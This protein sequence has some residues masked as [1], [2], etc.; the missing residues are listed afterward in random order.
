MITDERLQQL[1]YDPMMCNVTPDFLMCFRELIEA[2]KQLDALK[3]QVEK[4]DILAEAGLCQF[5]VGGKHEF[6]KDI[7]QI[8]ADAEIQGGITHVAARAVEKDR[9]MSDFYRELDAK[10]E[11]IAKAR[12]E[13]FHAEH[14]NLHDYQGCEND[15]AHLQKRIADLERQLAEAQ[16]TIAALKG[17]IRVL[18]YTLNPNTLEQMI[19]HGAV[20]VGD[21]VLPWVSK[22][23]PLGLDRLLYNVEAGNE[24]LA[25]G[26][27][28]DI[29]IAL[30][31]KQ[32]A[33]SPPAGLRAKEKRSKL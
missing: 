13:Q 7:R 22:N 3:E 23:S 14:P 24:K 18:R 29:L 4:M 12:V 33:I 15:P 11:G 16:A 17:E 10:E 28:E 31:N 19:Q 25:P 2:R 8:A 21:G 20:P 30:R 27:E 1:A 32:N 26:V 9:G 5:S 6:L